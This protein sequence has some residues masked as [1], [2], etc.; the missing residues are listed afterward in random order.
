MQ[1]LYI[2]SS[3]K[4]E[5]KQNTVSFVTKNGKRK[6]LPIE[7]LKEIYIFGEV[8]VNKRFL[9]FISQ[10]NICIHFFN[11]YG[12]YSGTFYPREKYNSGFVFVKQ[13]EK[14]LNDKERLKIAKKFV[15]GASQNSIETLKRYAKSESE[16]LNTIEEIRGFIKTIVGEV[17]NISQLMSLEGQIKKTYYS[18]FNLIL[19]SD[20]FYFKKREKRPPKTPLNALISFANSL[21][22]TVALGQIYNT[23]LDPRIGYLHTSNNRS[24]SLNL[25]VAE[26]FKP[27][28]ADRVLFNLINRN[29]LKE[30]HFIKQTNGVFLSEKGRKIFLQEFDKKLNSTIYN[31][32]LKRKVTLKN[33]IKIE[34]YKLEKH[35][36]DDLEYEPII[37]KN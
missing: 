9:D 16:I 23:H 5:R 32:S 10:K 1:S 7:N 27:A 4:L 29:Q 18:V 13:V 8:D 35:I 12:Y 31:K 25:D 30:K 11:Y 3:G 28:L 6:Y 24:F 26:I 21:V 36:I 15:I 17:K 2:T 14:Y 19:K 34:V 20:F 37:L 33:T 22:Y